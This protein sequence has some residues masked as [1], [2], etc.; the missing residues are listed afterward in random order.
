MYV[1]YIQSA[2]LALLPL[3]LL[4]I[5]F[6]ALYS[7][8]LDRSLTP[9]LL[10]LGMCLQNPGYLVC[11]YGQDPNCSET[12]NEEWDVDGGTRRQHGNGGGDGDDDG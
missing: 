3:S 1:S 4:S 10:V 8:P 7:S 2:E 6:Q 12:S 11:P 5:W 9:L